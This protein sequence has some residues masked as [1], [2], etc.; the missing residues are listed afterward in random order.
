VIVPAS[1]L[2][3]H[4]EGGTYGGSIA[5]GK[6]K[7]L[8]PVIGSA[9]GKPSNKK[10]VWDY[11]VNDDVAL[12]AA[13][14]ASKAV[15]ISSKGKV[16]INKTKWNSVRK[17]SDI[18]YQDILYVTATTTDGTGLSDT[19]PLF[20]H[21][22]P[23]LMALCGTSPDSVRKD[24]EVNAGDLWINDG[25][26]EWVGSMDI[27]VAVDTLTLSPTDVEVKSSNP[28]LIGVKPLGPYV[29]SSNQIV[30]ANYRNSSGERLVSFMMF[31]LVA[32]NTDVPRKGSAKITVKL[33][34]GSNKKFSFMVYL[35]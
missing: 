8:S 29:N 2:V 16:S 32:A 33:L 28:N 23:T 31:E 7:K 27:Y 9:Y 18:R 21:K 19:I 6:S 17:A 11:S 13:L 10:L 22:C 30:L 34:D 26:G 3:V 24:I 20:V 5:L 25:D 14:K 35:R 15:K 12:T 1:S 4:P